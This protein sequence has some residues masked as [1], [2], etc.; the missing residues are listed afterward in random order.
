MRLYFHLESED[1]QI[2]DHDGLE[3]E[4]PSALREQALKALEEISRE[5]PQLF[6]YG[7][8]WRINVANA[9]GVILFSLA[10]EEGAQGLRFT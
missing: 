7:K 8:G 5:N 4:D 3:I 6:Q 2:P 10:F 9:S 1:I